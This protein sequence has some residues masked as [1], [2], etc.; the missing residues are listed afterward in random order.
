MTDTPNDQQHSI[1]TPLGRARGL[2]S[3]HDGTHHWWMQR[4]S[5]I[6][7]A[8]LVLYL[9]INLRYF[10][11]P[12]Y[13]DVIVFVAS[14]DISLALILFTIASFYHAKLGVQVIIEDYI[15]TPLLK[16]T[17]LLANIFFF[18]GGAIAAISAIVYI[19]FG[20]YG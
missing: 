13:A 17:A 10:L 5:A 18:S 4:V 15:H 16:V 3:A 11:S 14:P 8:P 20:V 12:S 9:L 1:R 6:A 2:G 19:N 7:L